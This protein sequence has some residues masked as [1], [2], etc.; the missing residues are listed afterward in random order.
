MKSI[1]VPTDFSAESENALVYACELN[2]ELKAKIILFHSYYVPVPATDVPLAIVSGHEVKQAAEK[3]LRKLE[4]NYINKYPGM[5]FDGKVSEGFPEMEISNTAKKLECDLIIMGTMGAGGLKEIFI[6]TNTARVI[7]D[8]VCPVISIPESA[9]MNGVRKIVFAANYGNDDFSNVFNL[10][11]FARLYNSEIVLLHV[12]TGKTDIAFDHTEL[13]GFRRQVE[14]E[15]SYSNLSVKVLESDD[16][17]SAI[18]QF[19]VESKAD[20]LAI[21]MRNRT[22]VQKLGG[23]SMTKKMAYHTN[24]PLFVFHTSI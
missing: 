6:G 18:N 21:N 11:D 4:S 23:R 17:Y 10:I 1:L 5:L 24:I 15:S 2:K 20:M 13:D 19:L 7:E 9:R 12:S 16:I 14:S 3:S 22:F 8:S